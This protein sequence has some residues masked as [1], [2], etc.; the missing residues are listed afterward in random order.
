MKTGFILIFFS[1]LVWFATPGFVRALIAGPAKME[2]A[3]NPGDVLDGNF[4]LQNDTSDTKTFYPI[5]ERF[6]EE[7]GEKKFLSEKSDLST[8]VKTATSVTLTANEQQNLPFTIEIPQDAPP[9]GHFAVV[10]WSTAPPDTKGVA[11]VTRVGLLFLINVSGDIREGAQILNFNISGL[12]RFFGSLPINFDIEFKN[13]SNI[14]VKPTGNIEVKNIFGRLTTTIPVNGS[15][16]QIL[17]ASKRSFTVKWDKSSKFVF[18]RY[19]AAIAINYGQH[20]DKTVADKGFWFFIFPWKIVSLVLLG[21]IFIFVL[22]PLG[23][24]RYN[25]WIIKKAREG[26]PAGNN[27]DDDHKNDGNDNDDDTNDDNHDDDNHDD[28]IESDK[29]PPRG[30]ILNLKLKKEEEN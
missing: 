26:M 7:N 9:G 8:W 20:N 19:A 16:L 4:F 22:L 17:P 21:L 6:V 30:N 5:F 18:A 23:I 1:S 10:W 29:E 13:D 27:H 14:Y 12:K 24:R 25:R 15:D 2:Y 28:G 3:V 11:I